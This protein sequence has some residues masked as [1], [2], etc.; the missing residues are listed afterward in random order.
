M[1]SSAETLDHTS[2]S[3]NFG[4][5]LP[6]Q[7]VSKKDLLP[8]PK[9]AYTNIL[10]AYSQKKSKN[11]H[12]KEDA[13]N[14]GKGEADASKT[15]HVTQG[16]CNHWDCPRCGQV[17]AKREY[18]RIVGGVE[19]LSQTHDEL[20]FLT[21]TCR[22]KELSHVDADEGYLKWTNKLLDAYRSRVKAKDGAW[23]YVQVTERQKRGHPHSHFLTTFQPF[24]LEDGEVEKYQTVDGERR[25]VKKPALRSEWL[26]KAVSRS[27]LGEQYDISI[28][29]SAAAA[30]RYVAKY[31]FK[32]A[33]FTADWP[34][35]W[36]RVRY[37][38]SFP[39]LP[40]IKTDAFALVTWQ[41]WYKLAGLAM[42]V[43]CADEDTY[44]Y[45]TWKLYG[46][47]TFV[48]REKSSVG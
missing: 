3:P 48:E 41:D 6:P 5:M 40:H 17:R 35:K 30:S 27:G 25:M 15:Y 43:K 18:A 32:P 44:E 22:G 13:P 19:N 4:L 37:S 12:A 39:K 31:M 16:C 10:F 9:C 28:V 14:F 33:N 46:H 34:K 42:T 1:T 38:R 23:I 8:L 45:T 26:A 24:D 7:N 21:I 47:D 20:Y 2:I 36:R 11:Q 29:R